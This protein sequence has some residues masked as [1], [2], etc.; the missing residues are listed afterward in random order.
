MDGGVRAPGRAMLK[1]CA[2]SRISGDVRARVS[3]ANQE[4]G[5]FTR[6]EKRTHNGSM[7]MLSSKYAL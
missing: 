2:V 3:N 6:H 1:G 4:I 7:Q 5:K